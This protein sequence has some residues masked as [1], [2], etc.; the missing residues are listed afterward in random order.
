MKTNEIDHAWIFVSVLGSRKLLNARA[1][2]D[3]QS[4]NWLGMHRRMFA[5]YGGVMHVVMPD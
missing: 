1:A 5:F 2:E 4:R 3:M